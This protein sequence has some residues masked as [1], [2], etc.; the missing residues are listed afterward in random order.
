MFW[1]ILAIAIWGAVHSWLASLGVKRAVRRGTG[2]HAA[3][4]YRLAYNVFSA[5]TFIPI[6]VLVRLLPD[7]LLYAVPSPWLFLMLAGQLLAVL[8][9]IL[10]LLEVD[11]LSFVGLRQPFQG[12]APSHLVTGGF[13]RWVRHPLYLFG[14]LILWLTPVM[15]RNLLV[16]YVALSVYL[17]IGAMFEERKLL[18]EFGPA[19]A[20]YK[21]RTPMLIPLLRWTGKRTPRA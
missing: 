9:I 17:I 16:A 10:T 4:L 12:E 15:T 7:K 18:R 2:E 11:A 13:Y 8:C 21:A 20:Q 5:L 1:L 14:L 3:R 19:Y 6:L